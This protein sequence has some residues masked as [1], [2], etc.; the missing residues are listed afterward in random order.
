MLAVKIFIWILIIAFILLTIGLIA[1]VLM[2]GGG[3]NDDWEDENDD[4]RL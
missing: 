4:K 1:V 3:T 2:A